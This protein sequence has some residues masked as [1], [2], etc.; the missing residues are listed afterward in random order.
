MTGLLGRAAL[1][2]RALVW[3]T[4]RF[5]ERA[6]DARLAPLGLPTSVFRVLR[7]LAHEPG[8]SAAD[9]ARRL[10]FA[11]QSVALALDRAEGAGLIERRPHQTHGRIRQLYLTA[12]GQDAYGRAMEI[13]AAVEQDLAQDLS[14]ASRRQLWR[15]LLKL[16]ERAD[17]MA[18]TARLD[19]RRECADAPKIQVDSRR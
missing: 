5:I 3:R 18:G 17:Q 8:Q 12:A 14:A 1:G 9:L 19:R 13:I 15:Q 16:A 11:P 2:P 7:L 6:V 10:G 4:Q